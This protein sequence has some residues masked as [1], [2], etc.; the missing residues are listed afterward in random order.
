MITDSFGKLYNDGGEL[1]AEG[2]CQVDHDRGS[3]TLRPVIDTPLLTRQQHGALR[4][5]LDD[6]GVLAMTD[7]IIRFR[8]N[9][10]GVPSGPAYRLYVAGAPGLDAADPGDEAI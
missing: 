9:A 4:L 8:L 6:G 1:V 3:V 2:P 5:V 10:P 7:R